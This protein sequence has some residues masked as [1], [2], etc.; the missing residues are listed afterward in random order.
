MKDPR[1]WIVLLCCVTF[2]GGAGAGV[3]FSRS[4]TAEAPEGPFSGYAT[5]LNDEFQL[6]PERR[7]HL[8]VILR[9]YDADIRQ[10]SVVHRATYHELLQSDLRPIGIEYNGY[11]RDKVLR[12]EQRARFD[13][14]TQG[15]PFTSEQAQR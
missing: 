12:P 13:D 1:P 6:S 10:V 9:E 5:L 4:T 15:I 14:L 11:I 2:L 7:A 8:E 3:I